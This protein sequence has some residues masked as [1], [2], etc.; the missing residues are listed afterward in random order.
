MISGPAAFFIELVKIAVFISSFVT[1]GQAHFF[2][3]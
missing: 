3:S 2:D 1:S